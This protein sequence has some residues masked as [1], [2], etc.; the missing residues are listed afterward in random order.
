MAHILEGIRENIPQRALPVALDLATLVATAREKSAKYAGR[1]FVSTVWHLRSERVRPPTRYMHVHT[2]QP[3]RER[4]SFS[5]T[6]LNAR[7]HSFLIQVAQRPSA[8]SK[9]W[10]RNLTVQLTV[11]ASTP[12]PRHV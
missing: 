3:L 11:F 8:C 9:C 4:C 1:G 2:C 6:R 7:A 5:F 10:S 12:P